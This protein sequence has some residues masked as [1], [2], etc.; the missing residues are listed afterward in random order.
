MALTLG[1]S[2]TITGRAATRFTAATTSLSS[3]GSLEK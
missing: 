2:F 1:E 3:A